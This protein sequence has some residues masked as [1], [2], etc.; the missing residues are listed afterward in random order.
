MPPTWVLEEM[1]A[2]ERQQSEDELKEAMETCQPPSTGDTATPATTSAG[3]ESSKVQFNLEDAMQV[4]EITSRSELTSEDVKAMW[5]VRSDY[6]AINSWI[7]V[8]VKNM[9]QKLPE[10][11][12]LGFCYRG[13]E[14]RVAPDQTQNIVIESI[15]A[16]LKEQ[17]RQRK[18]TTHP[19]T[20]TATN[21]D[22][23]S[24]VYR[25]YAIASQLES[26]KMA[27]KDAL[28]AAMIRNPP[29][30]APIESSAATTPKATATSTNQKGRHPKAKRRNSFLMEAEDVLTKGMH[31]PV[32]SCVPNHHQPEQQPASC[33]SGKT[34]APG[35]SRYMPRF[36]F[37]R[38]LVR[39]PS[40]RGFSTRAVRRTSFG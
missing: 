37:R 21:P 39:T 28:E 17:A 30:E 35:K 3:R 19:T 11:E 31:Q 8:T 15:Y 22:I 33:K 9:K 20:S 23:L 26:Y 27:N 24:K 14:K 5:Y 34:V 29:P 18:S 38:G 32:D 40:K 2:R 25:S 1:E 36:L 7:R 6:Q 13:L 10:E 12:E 4:H 16:V